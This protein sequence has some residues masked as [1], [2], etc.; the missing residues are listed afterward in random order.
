MGLTEFGC[1]HTI[2]HARIDLLGD[3]LDPDQLIQFQVR[4]LCFVGLGL[5]VKTSFDVVVPFTG[6]LLHATGAHVMI[7]EG[8]AVG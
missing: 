6:K 8:E 4:T 3:I 2:L 1:G 5:S 7:R